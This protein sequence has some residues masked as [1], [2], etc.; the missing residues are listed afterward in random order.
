MPQ[1]VTA[2]F[3]IRHILSFRSIFQVYRQVILSF[4]IDFTKS[5]FY[6]TKI[7]IMKKIYK[8]LGLL[9]CLFLT[10]TQWSQAQITISGQVNNGTAG[11]DNA[12]VQ[13][14]GKSGRDEVLLAEASTSGGG[15]Y[16]FNNVLDNYNQSST[17]TSDD[18]FF[19]RAKTPAGYNSL[20]SD[21][22]ASTYL[23]VIRVSLTFPNQTS[24]GNNFTF[25]NVSTQ[26]PEG[27][28]SEDGTNGGNATDS[29]ASANKIEQRILFFDWTKAG[30]AAIANGDQSIIEVGGVR[31][32]AT[33]SGYTTTGSVALNPSDLN[34][35]SGAKIDNMYQSAGQE[36]WYTAGN[37]YNARHNWTVT[38]TAED[39]ASGITYPV[40][41][42]AYDLETTNSKLNEYVKY[43][44][45]SAFKLLDYFAVAGTGSSLSNTGIGFVEGGGTNS[46]TY[47]DTEF[48]AGNSMWYAEGVTSMDFEVQTGVLPA[49]VG[50]APADAPSI[51]NMSNNSYSTGG[52]NYETLFGSRQGAGM[53]LVLD[54]DSDKN[55]IPDR[56]E[57]TISGNVK[58]NNG[59]PLVGVTITLTKPDG[60]TVTTTTDMNGDYSFGKLTPGMYTVTETD[61]EGYTS[62][63]DSDDNTSDTNDSDTNANTN[64][65]M[66]TVDL[67]QY[68]D[69]VANNFVDKK[70]NSVEGTLYEDTN[71]DANVDGTATGAPGGN[72]MYAILVDDQGKVKGSVQLNANGTYKFENVPDGTYTVQ[73]SN[74]ALAIDSDAPAMATIASGYVSTG[75]NIGTT[76]NDGTV[77]GKS[78]SFMLTGNTNL[79]EV[80][81]G[82]KDQALPVVWISFEAQKIGKNAML[83]WSTASEINNAGYAIEYSN[84]GQSFDEVDFVKG[85]GNSTQVQSYTYTHKLENTLSNTAYYRLNQIDNDGRSS[86]SKIVSLSFLKDGAA[87]VFPN[88]AQDIITITVGSKVK[89]SIINAQGSVVK[90]IELSAGNNDIEIIDLAPGTYLIY[91]PASQ[92]GSFIKM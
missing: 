45:S 26:L 64:D 68:E 25:G 67:A 87:Q 10:A 56:Y 44:S 51:Y 54:C 76:G 11:I 88:P 21:T 5:E 83:K 37:E 2:Q 1:Q 46:I 85:V 58:D 84:D 12:T 72:A 9:V 63:S 3:L 8:S 52:S 29:G 79:T 59:N 28:C 27:N 75:E 24:S 7:S 30:G 91:S 39:I 40:N 13:L 55:G 33:V 48:Y 82:V 22:D 14:F 4:S 19:L 81:F 66:L 69:D 41:I 35:W 65:N 57:S 23:G 92:I 38:V 74:T 31:Y 34:V 20:T 89:A 78:S 60:S 90:N 80:N 71:D 49:N 32:T 17:E 62:V 50:H 77:D 47:R 16:S 43:S 18:I 42:I 53:A 6:L 36:G 86:Y 15:N 61:P 70:L 73:M